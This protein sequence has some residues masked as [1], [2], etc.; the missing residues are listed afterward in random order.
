MSGNAPLAE[1]LSAYLTR[2]GGPAVQIGAL[3][4]LAGGA[5]HET[6]AFDASSGD[7]PPEAL[8]RRRDFAH[9]LLDQSF[10]GGVTTEFA[11]LETRHA[12]A[13]PVPRPRYCES[14][15]QA[16]GTPFMIVER[17]AGTDLRKLLAEQA[18]NTSISAAQRHASGVALV[19]LQAQLHQLPAP[20]GAHTTHVQAAQDCVQHEITRWTQLLACSSR[21]RPLLDTAVQWLRVHAPSVPQPTLV[22]VG[23]DQVQA[24]GGKF[25]EKAVELRFPAY[26][27]H[28]R[29]KT[30]CRFD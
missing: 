19:A 20:P 12:A 30:G 29:G 3:R 15:P 28:G 26:D 4:R 24:M 7:G 27:A 17:A 9:G 22:R 11:L 2:H 13:V 8:V 23:D 25:R 1:A 16:L 5:S 6:W 18:R 14:S 10:A 21:A